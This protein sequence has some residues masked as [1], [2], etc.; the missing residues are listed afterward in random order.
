MIKDW[1]VSARFSHLAGCMKYH[2]G[3]LTVPIQGRYYIY[4]QVFYQTPGRI[5]I[6]VNGSV[7][8]MLQSPK[9]AHGTAYVG[10]IFN[11]KAGDVIT[12]TSITS[13]FRLFMW[14]FRTYFGAYLI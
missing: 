11:L 14:S 10:G 5:H 1:S 8:T 3:K 2:D 12:I 4:L 6:R 7:R 13:N 9:A